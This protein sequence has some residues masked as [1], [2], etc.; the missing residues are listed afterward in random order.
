MWYY[1]SPYKGEQA[2]VGAPA[3][4]YVPTYDNEG[5]QRLNCVYFARARAME[6]NGLSK[7]EKGQPIGE[8]WSNSIAQFSN[9]HTV[10]IEDVERD[11]TNNAPVKVFFR[12]G[13]WDNLNYDDGDLRTLSYEDFINRSGAGVPIAYYWYG[14]GPNAK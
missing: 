13:N 6:A 8:I 10:F 9:K 5:K 14:N 2:V 7:W 3:F 11:P 1:T 12:E 4:T